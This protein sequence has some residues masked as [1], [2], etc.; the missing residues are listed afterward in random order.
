MS[1]VT[2]N[3]PQHL[4]SLATSGLLVSVEMKIPSFTKSAKS[5]SGEMAAQ[6]GADKKALRATQYLLADHP[7]HV[8]IVNHR[9]TVTNWMDRITYSWNKSSNYLP[10][11][12]LPKFKEEYEILRSQFFKM[13]E[14][15]YDAY[16]GIVS[17]M[18]FKQGDMF[19]RNDYPTKDAMLKRFR[20]ELYMYDVPM[21]DFRCSIAQEIAEELHTT[22]SRQTEEIMANL[23]ADQFRRMGDVMRSI[24]YCCE[25]DNV[26]DKNGETK[27][28][29]RRIYDS[30]I[31]KAHELINAYQSFNPSSS[32]ELEQAR[33]ALGNVMRSYTAEDI[34]DSEAVRVQ[35]K[36]G[37]DDILS[38]FSV[39]A[40]PEE[41]AE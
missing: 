31:T 10:T 41:I 34:R 21:Q 20:M 28:K 13:V 40:Q 4:I 37:I 3:K 35:V 32:D 29:K 18:A 8:Q 39:F 6:K 17:D 25:V 9:Q 1:V 2:L 23:V 36:E 26:V 19:N 12:I 14:A 27:I 15:L 24:S 7:L 5:V 30:T 38:K 11:A 33:E 22:Y 16:D